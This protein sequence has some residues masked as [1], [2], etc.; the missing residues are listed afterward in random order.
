VSRW[1]PTFSVVTFARMFAPGTDARLQRRVKNSCPELSQQQR[2]S[3][4][5]PETKRTQGFSRSTVKGKPSIR[6][7]KSLFLP[8]LEWLAAM[9][10]MEFR[11]I[12]RGSPIKRTKWRGLVRNA[13]IALGNSDLHR[14]SA[15]LPKDHRAAPATRH[16][17]RLDNLGIC[18]LG[19]PLASNRG[20]GRIIKVKPC[21]AEL[22]LRSLVV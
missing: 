11:R 15:P 13:C 20:Q 7:R 14:G 22:V 6:P 1:A 2:G 18:H 5:R 17:T 4:S 12:F 21:A 9:D 19:A 8:R 16:V 3:R 10:E